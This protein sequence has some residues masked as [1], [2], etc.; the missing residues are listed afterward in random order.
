MLARLR[1]D[2][3]IRRDHEQN[4]VDAADSR[5]HVSHKAL[6]AGDVDKAHTHAI[7]LQESKA[8]I[9]GDAAAL[10]FFETVWIGSREGLDERGFA[11]VDVAGRADDDV[12]HC[13]HGVQPM[14][15]EEER[16][17]KRW[18]GYELSPARFDFLGDGE[19][20]FARI[21]RAGDRSA[22]H[23]VIR[24]RADSHG[25]EWPRAPGHLWPRLTVARPARR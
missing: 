17:V 13:V 16:G 6:V 3:F 7:K 18:V 15:A 14:L 5:Q 9:N 10:F 8:E 1:L 20:R 4:Q 24:A 22:D 19:S 11:V 2:G 23:E 25:R 12:L 21:G